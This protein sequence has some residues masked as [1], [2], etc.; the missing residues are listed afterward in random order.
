MQ[1]EV[2]DKSVVLVINTAKTGGK[3]TAEVL[4]LAIR[5]YQEQSRNPNIYRGKQS[6]KKLSRPGGEL[7]NI[8]ITNQNIKSFEKAAKKYRVNFALKKEAGTSKYYVFFRAPDAD[9]LNAAFAE[10]TARTL[11]RAKG[12]PSILKQL[13]HFKD[14]V[15]ASPD[16]VKT[17]EKGGMEL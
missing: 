10:Y 2:R 6:Y 8:E 13:S 3:L 1:D 12:K 14:I 15:K 5:H 7:K 16:K 17:R 11:N 4:K 9:S